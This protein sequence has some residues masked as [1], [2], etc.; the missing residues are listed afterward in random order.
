[1]SDSS[2]HDDHEGEKKKIKNAVD[3]QRL[4]L[5]KLMK[6]PVRSSWLGLNLASSSA[7]HLVSWVF[8]KEKEVEIPTLKETK[9]PRAFNPH[10]FVRNVMG[11]F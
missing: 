2:D 1:M 10:E 6:N 3:L 4:K 9:K 5:E 8:F 11:E 7:L